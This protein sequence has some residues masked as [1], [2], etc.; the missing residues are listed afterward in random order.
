MTSRPE[1]MLLYV[2]RNARRWVIRDRDGRF[3]TLS[4]PGDGW[5]E[6][7]PVEITEESVLE[8]VPGHYRGLLGLPT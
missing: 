6:R 3:W 4:T 5:N 7:Q 1:P 2:D 8:P